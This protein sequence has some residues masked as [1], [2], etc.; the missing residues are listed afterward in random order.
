MP[1]H[2]YN[3][4]RG[5]HGYIFMVIQNMLFCVDAYGSYRAM[6]NCLIIAVN[7]ISISKYVMVNDH[8]TEF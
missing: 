8:G 3:I 6:D 4:I 2:N 7:G 5:V 1:S